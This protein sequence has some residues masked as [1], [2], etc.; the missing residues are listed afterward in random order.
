MEPIILIALQVA[1]HTSIQSTADKGGS[2]QKIYEGT[3]QVLDLCFKAG[4]LMAVMIFDISLFCREMFYEI[5]MQ[6]LNV[7]TIIKLI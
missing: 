4:C 3:I 5:Q 6:T 2:L 7:K 1:Q